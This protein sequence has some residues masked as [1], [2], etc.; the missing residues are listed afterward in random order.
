MYIDL[1]VKEHKKRKNNFLPFYCFN[2]LMLYSDF[3]FYSINNSM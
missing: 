2:L 3:I 1:A